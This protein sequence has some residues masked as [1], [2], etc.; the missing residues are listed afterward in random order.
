MERPFCCQASTALE[1]AFAT[2]LAVTSS[3][4]RVSLEARLSS[5]LWSEC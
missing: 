1:T 3:R 2:M 4:A 5:L